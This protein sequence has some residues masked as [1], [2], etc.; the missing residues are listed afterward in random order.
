MLGVV[1]GDAV[2]ADQRHLPAAAQRAAVEAGHDRNA[3][4]LQ[5]AEALLDALDLG[6]HARRV[7][8]RHAH[9]ALEVGAGEEGLLGR[10]QDQALEAVLVLTTCSVTATRSSCHCRH[11]VLTG[12]SC[13]VEGDGGHAAPAAVS[14]MA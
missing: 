13:L 14:S 7:G 11:M 2:M 3:Q 10:G 5:R 12:E 8:R 9:H 4:R 6:K 1:D